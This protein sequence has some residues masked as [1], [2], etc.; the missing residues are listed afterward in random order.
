M[1]YTKSNIHDLE[2]NAAWQEILTRIGNAI[3]VADAKVETPGEFNQ[4]YFVGVR[5]VVETL[6]ALPQQLLEELE[7]PNPRRLR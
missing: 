1:I 7:N 6:R 2:A 4:G 5:G 3:K